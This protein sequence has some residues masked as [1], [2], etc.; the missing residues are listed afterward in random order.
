MALCHVTGWRTPRIRPARCALSCYPTPSVENGW[1]SESWAGVG[2]GFLRIDALRRFERSELVGFY[3]AF[4]DGATRGDLG[5][6]APHELSDECGVEGRRGRTRVNTGHTTGSGRWPPSAVSQPAQ[7]AS[8]EARCS[9]HPSAGCPSPESPPLG[10]CER[11]H[12][13]HL[14]ADR[15]WGRVAAPPGER[16]TD[17]RDASAVQRREGALETVALDLDLEPGHRR[18]L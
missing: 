13:P 14:T 6:V 2:V 8:R 7:R 10:H 5:R 1:G 9:H 16:W 17:R 15:P 12:S 4:T 3:A 11:Q 18:R